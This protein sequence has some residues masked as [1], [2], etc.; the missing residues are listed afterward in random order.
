MGVPLMCTWDDC[1]RDGDDRIQIKVPKSNGEPGY[2]I[3][4]F[5]TEGHRQMFYDRSKQ[6]QD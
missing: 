6:R 2:T 1:E 4:I 3:F 5:C